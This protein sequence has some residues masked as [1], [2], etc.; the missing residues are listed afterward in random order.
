VAEL[1]GCFFGR[2][3]ELSTR[4]GRRVPR[5]AGVTMS[6]P[7]LASSHQG[8]ERSAGSLGMERGPQFTVEAKRQPDS[9]VFP[10]QARTSTAHPTT[11]PHTPHPPTPRTHG[12]TR[13]WLAALRGL[14]KVE[15]A[16][17]WQP[18]GAWPKC[19]AG[20]PAGPGLRGLAKVS[21][22]PGQSGHTHMW[23]PA[24]RGLA[25]VTHRH[26]H[27]HTHTRTN[28]LLQ[29]YRLEFPSGGRGC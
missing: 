14:A 11:H 17:G 22:W 23:L 4:L 26:A 9:F 8:R 18:R 16:C 24:P 2:V 5:A 27:T 12:H 29:P 20:S 7:R 19:P 25:K 1:V 21:G 3:V 28:T 6:S 13:T 15:H 10:A